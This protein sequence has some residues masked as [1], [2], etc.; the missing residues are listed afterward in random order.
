MTSGTKRTRYRARPRRLRLRI[1]RARSVPPTGTYVAVFAPLATGIWGRPGWLLAR[2][3]KELCRMVFRSPW[4]L[5]CGCGQRAVAVFGRNF[6]RNASRL[7]LRQDRGAAGAPRRGDLRWSRLGAAAF[8]IFGA[9]GPG[10]VSRPSP[11]LGG[12]WTATVSGPVIA[13]WVPVDVFDGLVPAM[14]KGAPLDALNRIPVDAG[15]F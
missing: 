6:P 11:D 7:W 14:S 12:G 10:R 15:V 1:R 5:R 2:V 4:R 9:A 13:A 3:E 8:G